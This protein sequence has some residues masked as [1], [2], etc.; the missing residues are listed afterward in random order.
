MVTSM[1]AIYYDGNNYTYRTDYPKPVR[2]AG[3][4]LIKVLAAALCN[5]D[6]EILKGYRPSFRGIMGHEFVGVVEESDKKELIGKRVVGELNEGCGHCIYCRTGREKHCPERKVIGMEGMD[7]CFGE[8]M[9]LADHLLHVIP[10][11]LDT[12]TALFTESLAA[13]L[14]ISAMLHVNPE[15]NICIL[16]DGRLALMIAQVLRLSGADLT[17]AGKHEDKLELFESC[18]RTCMVQEVLRAAEENPEQT[19][20]I[21]VDATGSPAGLAMASKLVRRRGTIVL[22]STYASKTEVHMSYFVVNEIMIMGSRCGP[23]EP[24][25]SLLEKGL[26][27]LPPITFYDISQFEELL[28]A[29]VFKGGI[30]F[31]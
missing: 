7:G 24:A 20:E 6:R 12:K 4:S 28:Q 22:K 26:I 18:G 14:E 31:E 17:I 10:D 15:K 11:A 3:H 9:V 25:L 8:Y 1:K 21:V 5:T 29:K 2:S 30:S 19:Y 23:F 27:Q 13:A 16:G